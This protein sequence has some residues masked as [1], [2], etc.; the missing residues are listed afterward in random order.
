[1]KPAEPREAI[2]RMARER[3]LLEVAPT[4]Q[5]LGV[6]L[7][8]MRRNLRL[9]DQEGQ[10]RRSC[11]MHSPTE[12]GRFE[13]PLHQRENT[14]SHEK[15]ETERQAAALVGR[16]STIFL[17]DGVVPYYMINHLPIDGIQTVV[18][19]SLRSALAVSEATPH[20]VIITGGRVR[21]KTYAVVGRWRASMFGDIF[22]DLAFI[23]TNG[24]STTRGL[25]APNPEVAA[26]KQVAIA[27]VRVKVL[28]CERV[29]FGVAGFGR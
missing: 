19:I 27:K 22:V 7:G 2:V 18:T 23:G 4:A 16:A 1:M 15:K 14:N 10:A 8:T 21:Q 5:E 20:E 26:I 3:G 13:S 28:L 11:G 17:D 24:I 9:L 12:I 6:P 25:T 29:K